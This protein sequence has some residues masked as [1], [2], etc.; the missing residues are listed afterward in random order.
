MMVDLV[1]Q[2]EQV[3]NH[4]P[5]KLE[6]VLLVELVEHLPTKQEFKLVQHQQIVL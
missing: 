6:Q 5:L 3:V 1:E 4:Q 2:V